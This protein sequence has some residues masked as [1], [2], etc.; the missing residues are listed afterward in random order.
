M[1]ELRIT[2]R[3]RVHDGKAEQVQTLAKTCLESVRNKDTGTLGYEWFR[4]AGHTEYV[5]LERYRDSGAM[6]EHVANL[7]ETMVALLK[8][9]EL[10]LEVYGTPSDELTNALE[11]LD[12]TVY[13]YMQGL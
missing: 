12:V 2:A 3:L 10:S 5:V 8:V 13:G 6:L 11:G 7:G 9:A 1:S 4:S